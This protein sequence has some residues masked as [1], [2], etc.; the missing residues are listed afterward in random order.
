MKIGDYGLSKEIFKVCGCCLACTEIT[1]LTYPRTHTHHTHHTHTHTPRTHHT[2]THTPHTH[3]PRTHHTHTHHTHHT[4]ITCSHPSFHPPTHLQE[5]YYSRQP[6]QTPLP[7]RWMAPELI[8]VQDDAL[9]AHGSTL[10]GNVWWVLCELCSAATLCPTTAQKWGRLAICVYA[11][12]ACIK[13]RFVSFVAIS[14]RPLLV[15]AFCR[16]SL[17]H[18]EFVLI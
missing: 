5:D 6:G 2:R 4:A 16:L 1:S 9:L 17:R 10:S 3:T 18:D 14:Q 13:K 15:S 8:Y 7:I 11:M 12:Q